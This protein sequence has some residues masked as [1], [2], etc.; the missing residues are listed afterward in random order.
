[1]IVGSAVM[2]KVTA[3]DGVY[4]WHLPG[5]ERVE[6]LRKPKPH[7]QPVWFRPSRRERI[8]PRRTRRAWRGERR[9]WRIEDSGSEDGAPAQLPPSST[10]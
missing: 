4:Q 3:G 9:G 2:E 7:P 6:R 1:V 5:A 8:E 10:R